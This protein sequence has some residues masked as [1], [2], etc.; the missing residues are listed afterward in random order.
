MSRGPKENQD[1]LALL[2]R[3]EDLDQLDQQEPEVL[4]GQWD[5]LAQ[6]ALMEIQE[7]QENK[8]QQVF[9]GRGVRQ[10]KTEK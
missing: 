3:M 8:G 5:Y 2:E 9:Q 10:G 6:R 7:R 4:Q 1:H